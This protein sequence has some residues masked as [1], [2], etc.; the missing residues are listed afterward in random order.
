MTQTDFRNAARKAGLALAAVLAAPFVAGGAEAQSVRIGNDPQLIAR[1]LSAYG[2]RPEHRLL[3]REVV[4]TVVEA[5]RGGEMYRVS[6]NILGAV[7]TKER[8]GACNIPG[9]VP[10]AASGRQLTPGEV[11]DK[12]RR[13]GY[14]R[15]RFLDRVLP[16][17]VATACDGRDRAVELVLNR[18]GEVRDSKVIGR[19]RT[20]ATTQKL[21]NADEV[22]KALIAQGYDRVRIEDRD[23]PFGVVAC[24]GNR[25]ERLIIDRRGNTVSTTRA[26]ECPTAI[27]PQELAE[28]LSGRDLTRVNVERKGNSF[29]ATACRGAERLRFAFDLAGKRLSRRP[30]GTCEARTARQII[31][32]LESRGANDLRLVVVGCFKGDRYRWA[33]NELGD[34]LARQKVGTC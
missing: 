13:G 11:R 2:F 34:R 10:A 14:K 16:R 33:F 15:I 19:C 12:L 8:R 29:E 3:D 28:R 20:E 18:R 7:S 5:C 6:V 31:D 21:V 25:R 23:A 24:R 32:R 22:E 27:A 30:A 9:A 4:R 17:Y 1:A 26:G